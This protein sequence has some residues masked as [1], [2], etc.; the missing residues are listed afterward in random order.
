MSEIETVLDVV[1]NLQ[2]EFTKG[3]DKMILDF[4]GSMEEVE[5]QTPFYIIDYT[6]P[7]FEVTGL[8]PSMVSCKMTVETFLRKRTPEEMEQ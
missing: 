7:V 3:V 4:F 6:D 8:D 1:S 5:K 2:S